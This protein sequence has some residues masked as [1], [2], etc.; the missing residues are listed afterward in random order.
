MMTIGKRASTLALLALPVV[1]AGCSTTLQGQ[2]YDPKSTGPYPGIPV[3][4]TRP[5]FDV[6]FTEPASATDDPTVV[7][8]LKYIPDFNHRYM[9]KLKPDWLSSAGLD[10]S[11]GAQG[12]LVSING[13]STSG[14]VA[15]INTLGK[16]ATTAAAFGA[17]DKKSATQTLADTLEADDHIVT[18]SS[19]RS[20]LSADQETFSA[21]P[22]AVGSAAELKVRS[23]LVDRLRKASAGLVAAETLRYMNDTELRWLIA[24]RCALEMR[25]FSDRAGAAIRV[26]AAQARALGL[27]RQDIAAQLTTVDLLK[28]TA[29]T[30]K[31]RAVE[32]ARL[33]RGIRELGLRDNDP[34]KPILDGLLGSLEALANVRPDDALRQAT[35]MVDMAPTEWRRRHVK[36]IQ[37]ELST[38]LVKERMA[39]CIAAN[40]LAGTPGAETASGTSPSSSAECRS[41]RERRGVLRSDLAAT[42]QRMM[43]T[44]AFDSLQARVTARANAAQLDPKFYS[45][46]SAALD[47]AA[48]S[49]E[50]A[51]ASLAAPAAAEPKATKL[52]AAPLLNASACENKEL[53]ECVL[54][55]MIAGIPSD[56]DDLPRFVVVIEREGVR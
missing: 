35:S 39:G 12:Q 20:C 21:L 29:T 36:A 30:A 53:D 11:I 50:K 44:G 32:M 46:S 40:S 42:V 18:S 55:S 14:A 5:Q 52:P 16:L 26:S 25:M 1:L 31:K 23:V 4:M 9:L 3:N 49:I 24:G 45:Q 7:L 10:F 13:A 8:E 17:F 2:R 27:G 19:I 15:A 6:T 28:N 22:M 43:E 51:I 47:L 41:F 48:A 37:A 38:L 33:R 34:A 56:S 54:E